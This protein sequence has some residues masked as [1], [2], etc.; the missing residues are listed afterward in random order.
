M[1]YLL[2][3]RNEGEFFG[4]FGLSGKFAGIMG[5]LIF[6]I[7]GSITNNSRIGMLSVA[8]FFA[9]GFVLLLF[10]KVQQGIEFARVFEQKQ[11]DSLFAQLQ[12]IGI[13][14]TEPVQKTG[15]ELVFCV[16]PP[17]EEEELKDVQI[18]L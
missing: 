7:F 10:V 15:D 13:A 6:G 1:S 8:A 4:F 16:E 11:Q 12:T 18:K 17:H 14:Q 2:I 9:I 3:T 5:P